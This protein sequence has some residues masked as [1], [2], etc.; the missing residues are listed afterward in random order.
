MAPFRA[1]LRAPPNAPSRRPTDRR[2]PDPETQ[3]SRIFRGWDVE[4]HEF[5]WMAKI[6][7]RLPLK[8]EQIK[9]G[10]GTKSGDC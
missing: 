2:K 6:K 4:P 5:P 9:A 8:G 3:V 7:V 1:P 10:L